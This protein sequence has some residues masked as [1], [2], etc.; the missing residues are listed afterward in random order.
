MR[1]VGLVA[2]ALFALTRA[3]SAAEVT[4]LDGRH[5]PLRSWF[6]RAAEKPRLLLLLSPT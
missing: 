5:E 4:P 3:A 2:L 6:E 1:R